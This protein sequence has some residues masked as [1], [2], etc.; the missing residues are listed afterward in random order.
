MRPLL[1]QL[2]DNIDTLI[3][4]FNVEDEQLLVTAKN[5]FGEE[6]YEYFY[7]KLQESVKRLERLN[8]VQKTVL[9]TYLKE[10]SFKKVSALLGLCS[11]T[12][13]KSVKESLEILRK[14][15]TD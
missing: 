11:K 7:E 12:A 2:P 4:E 10:K 8:I 5:L 13:A 15:D 9:L 3:N 6:D 1:K 14:N